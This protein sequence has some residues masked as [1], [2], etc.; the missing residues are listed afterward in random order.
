MNE[1]I[2]WSGPGQYFNVSGVWYR[3]P[4]MW[5]FADSGARELLRQRGMNKSHLNVVTFKWFSDSEN[6]EK[7]EAVYKFPEMDV[8]A[9][10]VTYS[11]KDRRRGLN[12][13]RLLKVIAPTKEL[14]EQGFYTIV[15]ANGVKIK[16][17]QLPNVY[18]TYID[19]E[20]LGSLTVGHL[21]FDRPNEAFAFYTGST[22]HGLGGWQ[23]LEVES[24]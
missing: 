13:D 9:C 2:A 14:A 1:K 6:L 23:I 16:N 3:L 7:V 20:Y 19:P 10:G 22:L 18:K 24:E 8:Y 21:P 4:G 11:E 17:G 5:E 15:R 12:H